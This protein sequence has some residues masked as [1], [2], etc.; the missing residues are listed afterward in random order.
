MRK[1]EKIAIC[2]AKKVQRITF[3][4]HQ[5]TKIRYKI[6]LINKKR[7]IFVQLLTCFNISHKFERLIN[8]FVKFNLKIGLFL[9]SNEKYN[10]YYSITFSLKFFKIK[11]KLIV[12]KML[13]NIQLLIKIYRFILDVQELK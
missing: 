5:N 13:L 7:K 4:Y 6:S 12:E 1:P 11:R 2:K 8:F 9:H 10:L 3:N